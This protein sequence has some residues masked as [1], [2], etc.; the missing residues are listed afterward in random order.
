LGKSAPAGMGG[1]K[2]GTFLERVTAMLTNRN[3]RIAGKKDIKTK[4]D[5]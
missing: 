1:P 5:I 4:Q 2:M 3:I